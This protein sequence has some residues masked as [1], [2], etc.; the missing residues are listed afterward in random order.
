MIVLPNN[1]LRK[2]LNS[3]L[4]RGKILRTKLFFPTGNRFKRMI[5]LNKDFSEDDIFYILTT[6]KVD[7]FKDHCNFEGIKGNFIYIHKGQTHVNPNKD[8]VLDCRRIDII[9][10]EKLFERYKNNE[11][12]F[13]G[14]ISKEFMTAIDKI[15]LNSRMISPKIKKHI[16]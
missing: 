1:I 2:Q 15:V 4:K 16:L 11:L 6:S 13:L 7:F 12:N 3:Q 14:E 8:V 5:L 9:K 10:K